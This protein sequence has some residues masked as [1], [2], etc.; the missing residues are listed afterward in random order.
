M[1][2]KL[3]TR[4]SMRSTK[5]FSIASLACLPLLACGGDDGGSTKVKVVDAK[6]FKD[7]PASVCGAGSSYPSLGNMGYALDLPAHQGSDGSTIPREILAATTLGSGT[8]ASGLLLVSG[9]GVFTA[10][11]NPA[12]G[13][14]QITGAEASFGTCAMCFFLQAGAVENAANTIG[15]TLD[16]TGGDFY[17]AI[18]GTLTFTAIGSDAG[19]GSG[20]SLGGTISN[21]TFQKIDVTTG[22][23][24]DDGCMT[25][26]GSGGWGYNLQMAGSAQARTKKEI[27]GA[28]QAQAKLSNRSL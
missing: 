2:A 6:V 13:T 21:V 20:H 10:T 12:P 9:S 22:D 14:Y 15:F 8:V 3:L 24:T 28:M 5:K 1:V 4:L 27:L 7:A 25:T 11:G 16:G 23:P 26:V 18:S 19:S 17:Q